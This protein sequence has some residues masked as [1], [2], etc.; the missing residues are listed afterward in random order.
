MEDKVCG[1]YMIKNI[2]NNKVYVGQSIDIYGRWTEHIC[3]LRGK[4]HANNHLQRSW[5]KY[6]EHSF[7]FSIIE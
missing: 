3:A 5:N 1:I 7:E 4:Y 2:V 6:Q